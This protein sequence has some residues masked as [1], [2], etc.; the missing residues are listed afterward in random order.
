M[1]AGLAAASLAGL[2]LLLAARRRRDPPPR[3][4]DPGVPR[5]DAPRAEVADAP[6]ATAREPSPAALPTRDLDE[7]LR[8]TGGSL[9]IADALLDQMLADLPGQIEVVSAALTV[10]DWATLRV[11]APK[12]KGGTGVC[13]VPA[14][15]AAVC[16]L[17]AA[18]GREDAAATAAALTEIDRERRRLLAPGQDPAAASALAHASVP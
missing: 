6:S 8:I 11:L 12:I 13:A 5:L 2:V 17:Q 7:A 1:G 15:H 14:L 18:T 9:D 10:G 4:Q 16:R 3:G